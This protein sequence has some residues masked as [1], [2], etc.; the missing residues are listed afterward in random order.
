MGK[1]T[2]GAKKIEE[3]TWDPVAKT[4]SDWVELP[5][6]N[7]TFVLN[8]AEPSVNEHKQQGKSNPRV[9]RVTPASMAVTYQLMDTD[10]QALLKA[11]G[12]SVNAV[13]GADVWSA[14]KN[15]GEEIKS[16][17][18]TVEDDSIIM[19]PAFSRYARP[20]LA[21]TDANINLI[22]VSGVVTDTGDDELPDM[23][24]GEKP[25]T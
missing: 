21:I 14:P 12:G 11:F 1:V 13:D 23:T 10:P 24:W 4:T 8:E 22:D 25:T 16:L 15:R 18:I 3:G 9:R 6:Y 5:V 17:R 2:Y 7:E 19:I 20:N